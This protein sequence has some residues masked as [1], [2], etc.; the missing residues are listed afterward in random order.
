MQESLEEL[1]RP[2][3]I[4]LHGVQG[5]ASS[6]LVA[7]TNS[8]KKVSKGWLILD[9]C[10]L[11]KL[12]HF[13]S[14]GCVRR[15]ILAILWALCWIPAIATA[16]TD[17]IQ[18]YD[19]EIAPPGV[20]NLTWHNNYTP[21]GRLA[22]QEPGGIIP[23]HSLN[24]V[25]EFAYGVTGW[26]EAGLYLPLYTLTGDGSL[27][28]NGFKLR[29]LFVEPNAADKVFIYGVNF[30]FSYNEPHWDA[31][32]YTQEIRP[33]IGWHL[34]RLDIIINPILDNDYEGPSGL[35]FAP[36]TRLAWNVTKA[37]AVAAEEYADFGPVHHFYGHDLQSQQLFGVLD[38]KSN[39]L[40]V[41]FGVGFGL[42]PS[43]DHRVIKLILSR[44]LNR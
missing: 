22:A 33:I 20:F 26:F 32:R 6:N 2:Q 41:E 9:A 14:R 19:A 17:E 34:G 21:S 43:S 1:G 25:P 8:T 16:Q 42:T 28:F 30:E 3:M 15:L 38:Y 44:N 40:T 10:C 31:H 24:G 4:F 29:A 5:V 23:N 11:T 27:L 37:F 12:L 18:V 36:A 35:D 7:P 13:G 39:T